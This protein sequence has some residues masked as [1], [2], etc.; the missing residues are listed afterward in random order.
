MKNAV[1]VNALNIS[2]YAFEEFSGG[3][4]AFSLL[5]KKAGKLPDVE[6]LFVFTTRDLGSGD[7]D[8]GVSFTQV[9]ETFTGMAQLL[10]TLLQCTGN[11]RF[12]NVFYLF[13]DTPLIDPA[14]TERMYSNHKKYFA[15]YTFAEGFPHGLAP[16]ILKTDIFPPLIR[17]AEKGS[18]PVSRDGIFEVI[19]KDI[20]FFDIETELSE[21]DQR[22]LRVSLSAD[23]KRNF[24]QMKRIFDAGGKDES[25]ITGIL[26]TRGD[27][28]RVEPAFVNV[29]ISGGCPQACSYCPYP[30]INKDLLTSRDY[31]SLKDWKIILAKVHEY[32]DDAV[33]SVSLWGE[34]SLHP[35][36]TA[37]VE[38]LLFYEKF[39]LIIETS[40]IGWKKETLDVLKE[41]DDGRLS[42]ILSLDAENSESYRTLRGEGWEEALMAAEYLSR[43]FG[44]RFYIQSVR[45]KS[46]EEYLEKFFRKWK[47]KGINTIIQKYDNFCSVLPDRKVTDISPLLRNP[48]WHIKRDLTILIDGTVQMCREDLKNEFSLGNILK[49]KLAVI[50]ERGTPLYQKHL[51]GDY[52]EICRKCDEYYTY[53]F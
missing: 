43:G 27:L 13:G 8:P 3:K 17:L 6:E 4:S 11:G 23:T 36:I 32:S 53:N 51:E 49:E 7:L 50:W 41:L 33:F 5:L 25:S 35:D 46:N 9:K 34:P 42:W 21:K 45:M 2:E 29:Q 52:P 24:N 26:E 37:F 12:D 28:L 47:D 48:C 22:M 14:L 30:G 1:V 18:S 15:S 38:A 20:N 44:E 40:G 10:E 19:K 39:S 16:E 31:M